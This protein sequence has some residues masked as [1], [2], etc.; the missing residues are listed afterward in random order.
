MSMKELQGLIYTDQ[1]LVCL[2]VVSFLD[3]VVLFPLLP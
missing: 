1:A 3:V 2:C